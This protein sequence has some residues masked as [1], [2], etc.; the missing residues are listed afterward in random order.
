MGMTALRAPSS[1]SA[2]ASASSFFSFRRL[3]SFSRSGA[4]ASGVDTRPSAEQPG[5]AVGVGEGEGAALGGSE[6]MATVATDAGGEGAPGAHEGA[7]GGRDEAAPPA[8]MISS[9]SW[10]EAQEL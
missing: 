9:A 7:R 4:T 6:A 10:L 3:G 2:S 1:T 8:A 5:A